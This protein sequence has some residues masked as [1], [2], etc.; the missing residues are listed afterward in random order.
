MSDVSTSV[1]DALSGALND[2]GD[3]LVRWALCAEVIDA[4]GERGLWTLAPEGQK[5]WDTLG[6][7]TYA[8]QREQAEVVRAKLEDE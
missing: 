8:T 2:H 3:M 5:A 6:L 4:E 1:N 7:L